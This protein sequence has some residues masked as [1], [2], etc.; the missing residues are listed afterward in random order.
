MQMKQDIASALL[1]VAFL[2]LL[3]TVRLL[4]A[5]IAVGEWI[6]GV[7]AYFWRTRSPANSVAQ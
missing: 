5:G 2:M 6:G 1:I 3:F 4:I 7:I